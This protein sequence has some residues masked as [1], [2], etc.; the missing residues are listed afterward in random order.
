M[1][2]LR[3][4]AKGVGYVGLSDVEVP[5]IEDDEVLLKVWACAASVAATC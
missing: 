3:K 5:A 1:K 4:L 2:A